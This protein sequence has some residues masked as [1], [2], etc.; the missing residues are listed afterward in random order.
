MKDPTGK[1]NSP[2][3]KFILFVVLIGI[4]ILASI[5]GWIDLNQITSWLTAIK[6]EPSAP[7]L[8]GLIYF[9]GVVL[10]LPG[11]VLTLFAGATFGFWIGLVVT[12]V[13]ANLGCMATFWL[14]RVLGQ[15]MVD[16]IAKPGKFVD[17]INTM[18]DRN[19]FLVMLY[20]RLIPAIPFNAIN[21]AM[22]MTK[23]KFGAY[24]LGN[25][26]GMIPGTAVYIYL[27]AS[28][29]DIR[30]RP[31]GI[32]IPLALLVLLSVGTWFFKKKTSPA[33]V[34]EEEKK[35]ADKP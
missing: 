25:L 9:A 27:A 14:S 1:K 28:V 3:L 15:G 33:P 24:V 11:A 32:I 30:S 10:A 20:L 6:N 16:R 23:I 19:G 34:A 17:K 7:F 29:V 18:L 5:M 35:G 26:V 31:E 12:V 21:Y 22:G 8:F 13:A 4:L 2:L